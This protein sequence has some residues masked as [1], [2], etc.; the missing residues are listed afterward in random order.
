[1]IAASPFDNRYSLA[2]TSI[3]LEVAHEHHGIS[4]IAHLGSFVDWISENSMLNE[5]HDA[6]DPIVRQKA[7]QLM[8][9]NREQ[10]LLGHRLHVAIDRIDD[11]KGDFFA[12]HSSHYLAGKLTRRE[13]SWLYLLNVELPV[14]E[15]TADLHSQRLRPKPERCKAL[16]EKVEKHPLSAAYRSMSVLGAQNGFSRARGTGDQQAGSSSEPT[17]KHCIQLTGATVKDI[18]S[19]LCARRVVK[20]S[21]VNFKA[22]LSDPEIMKATPEPCASDLYH[23]KPP[24]LGSILQRNMLEADHSVR[25]AV[26]L[27]VIA[28]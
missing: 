24:A 10:S 8:H 17:A 1:V 21:R 3:H 12:L 16:V 4:E 18:A 20:D 25:Q 11:D 9:L 26:K 7:Q 6:R 2:H 23:M 19:K 13:I 27:Q 5:G 14:F 22:A 28:G 15:R